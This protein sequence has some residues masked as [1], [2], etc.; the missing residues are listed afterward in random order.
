MNQPTRRTFMVQAVAAGVA[1]GASRAQA[2]AKVEE[3]DP[4]AVTLGYKADT[5]KVDA[6]KYPNHA[7]TQDCANCQLYQG[8][9]KDPMG[10]CPLFANKQVAASGW[11]SAWAKKP[12]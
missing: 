7:A 4:T 5:T 9:A 3:S 10:P 11:C 8:K 12:G 2:Q 1:L 6:K